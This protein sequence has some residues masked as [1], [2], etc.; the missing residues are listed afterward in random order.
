MGFY[1]KIYFI[2]KENVDWVPKSEFV[3]SLLAQA[4]VEGSCTV[5]GLSVPMYWDREDQEE[6]Y[7]CGI[8]LEVA[9]GLH[10]KGEALVIHMSLN[11]SPWSKAVAHSLYESL[12]DEVRGNM[13]PSQPSLVLGPWS[14][15]PYGEARTVAQGHFYFS[16]SCSG[17]PND[18]S[19]Y[20]NATATCAP[21][22]QMVAWLE[23]KTGFQW[24]TLVNMS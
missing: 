10:E 12:P 3:L 14:I 16:L 2:P 23:S 22:Q 8:P 11:S 5:N 20:Q 24:R 1:S 18:L 17:S 9:A 15:C 6:S 7:A 13:Y 19:A 21:V 4:G